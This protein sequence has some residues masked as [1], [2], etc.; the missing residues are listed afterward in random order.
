MS[1]VLWAFIAM[2]AY[3][4]VAPFVSRAIG[5]GMPEFLVLLITSVM[6]V[7]GSFVVALLTNELHWRELGHPS[8]WN[9]YLGGVF[10]AVGIASY[11]RAL[12]L[13]AVSVVV[14][15]SRTRISERLKSSCPSSTQ[16]PATKQRYW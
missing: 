7:A 13:G 15:I 9:A 3:S 11:Y 8:A 6:L 5:G 14:P 12:S 2:F 10:L 4:F 16:P 1:A